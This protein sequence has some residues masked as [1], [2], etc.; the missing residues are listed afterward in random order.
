MARATSLQKLSRQPARS[1]ALPG[2][3][4]ASLNQEVCHGLPDDRLLKDGDIV[5]VDIGLKYNDFCGDACVTYAVGKIS[6]QAQKLMDVTQECLRLGIEASRAGNHLSDIGLAIE[7]YAK[8]NG[9]S[10]VREWG[11]HGIGRNCMKRRRCRTP[12]PAVW[13]DLLPGMVFTIEPMINEG[14]PE[15]KLLNDGWTVVTKMENSRRS[16][17]TQWW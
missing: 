2:V 8:K 12:D 16:L 7:K 4:C 1:S 9:F 3:I 17:N 13:P 5:A 10:V 14:R 11:G 6:P 15:W